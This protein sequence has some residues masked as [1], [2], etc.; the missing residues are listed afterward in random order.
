MDCFKISMDYIIN[1]ND[2]TDNLKYLSLLNGISFVKVYLSHYVDQ[3][4]NSNSDFCS[5]ND[6]IVD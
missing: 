1:L 5:I 3:S 4:I 2:K 6:I